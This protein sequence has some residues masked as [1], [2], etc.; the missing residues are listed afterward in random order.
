[1]WVCIIPTEAGSTSGHW[2]GINLR[3]GCQ[4]FPC[5]SSCGWPLPSF[6][7]YCGM[8]RVTHDCC[9]SPAPEGFPAHPGGA[10]PYSP[11]GPRVS[12]SPPAA[13]PTLYLLS[14]AIPLPCIP[15]RLPQCG[16]CWPQFLRTNV[17]HDC[18]RLYG[19]DCVYIQSPEY[20]V[21]AQ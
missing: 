13:D 9:P 16:S 8:A 18:V 7:G 17:C 20:E 5:Y 21:V 15:P 19:Q 14:G 2:R 1:M 6:R 11:Q 3:P 10:A 4:C 12:S